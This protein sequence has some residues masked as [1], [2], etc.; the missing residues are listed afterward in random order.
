VVVGSPSFK[1]SDYIRLTINNK[2]L[3]M[4]DAV[5]VRNDNIDMSIMRIVEAAKDFNRSIHI[6]YAPGVDAAAFTQRLEF[7]LKKIKDTN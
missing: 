5:E 4:F 6:F 7:E 3:R 1:L 2:E